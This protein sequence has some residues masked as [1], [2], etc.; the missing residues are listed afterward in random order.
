ML[1][2]AQFLWIRTHVG[3]PS[4]SDIELDALYEAYGNVEQVVENV[5]A[6]RLA[7][8]LSQPASFSVRRGQYSQNTA[9]NI[10][11]LTDKLAAFRA[12]FLTPSST[13]RILPKALERV[14]DCRCK[15][16]IC[17]HYPNILR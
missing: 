16:H 8:L 10:K 2:E 5:L 13:S 3:G 7:N 11:A 4:P 9:A 15:T 17:P 6:T 12:E 14:R 1:D